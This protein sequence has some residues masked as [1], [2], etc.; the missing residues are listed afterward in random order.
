MYV[1]K[2][3]RNDDVAQLLQLMANH[4]FAVLAVAVEGSVQ[5]THIP[6]LIDSGSGTGSG[7]Q[8]AAVRF[9]L[10]RGNAACAAL[11]D[12]REVLLIFSGPNAY[13]SPDWYATQELVPTWNHVAVHAYGTP[14]PL[15]DDDLCQLLDDLSAV[16]EAQLPKKPWTSDKL[17]VDHYAKKRRAIVG[18]RMPIARLE[19]KWKL[20]QNRAVADRSGVIEHLRAVGGHDQCAVA[21]LMAALAPDTD[22]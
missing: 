3:F 22:C 9:H 19:G 17:P 5:A 1:P 20:T 4:P 7:A 6:C 13:V 2:H 10:A 16:F 15:G 14:Q 11:Q 8:G 18:F 21:D 12:D